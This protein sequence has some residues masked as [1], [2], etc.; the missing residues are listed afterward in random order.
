MS[1]TY[2]TTK[3]YHAHHGFH[4]NRN[5]NGCIE[6]TGDKDLSAK[7]DGAFRDIGV[8]WGNHRHMYS[9]LKVQKR[10]IA[11]RKLGVLSIQEISQENV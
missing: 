4:E 2:K 8:R 9:K 5:T 10:K 3:A 7:V 1:K 6:T 11:R